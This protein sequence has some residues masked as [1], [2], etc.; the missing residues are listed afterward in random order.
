MA[1]PHFSGDE[2]EDEINSK[3]WLKMIKKTNLSPYNASF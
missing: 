2:D 3:E 1:I